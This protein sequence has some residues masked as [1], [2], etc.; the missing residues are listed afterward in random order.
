MPP[1]LA[2]LLFDPYDVV[3]FLGA[4]T[5]RKS[6]RFTNLDYQF[7]G[8][9]EHRT[10]TAQRVIA[11]WKAEGPERRRHTGNRSPVLISPSGE[12]DFGRFEAL[13]RQR[14]NRRVRIAE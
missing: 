8:P 4:D 2:Q 9:T 10:E 11:E 7:V 6:T 13:Y 1:V 3:R 12:F 5:L 14:D